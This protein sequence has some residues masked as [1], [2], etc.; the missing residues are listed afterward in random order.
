MDLDLLSRELLR[1]LRGRRSQTAL[2]RRLGYQSNVLYTWEAGHRAPTAAE[3]LRLASR[4]GVDLRAA[5]RRFY[6]A[7]PA[8]LQAHDPATPA[9]VAAWLT[10]LR[11]DTPL[12]RVAEQSGLSRFAVARALSGETEPRLPDFL[13]LFEAMSLRVLDL[14]AALTDPELL[15]S[16]RE[17]WRR[18]VAQRRLAVEQPFT[19][20]VLRAVELQDYAD[21]PRHEEGW[22]AR[23]LGIAPEVE[24]A[25]LLLLGEA[26]ELRWDGERWRPAEALA[27]DTR[28]DPERSRQLK[29]WWAQVGLERLGQDPDGMW[30]YNVVS[31]SEADLRH[32]QELYRACFRA[33]RT[34]VAR[35]A[36]AER[37]VL[38]NTQVFA[39]DALSAPE[40]DLSV[41]QQRR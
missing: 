21:L 3:A 4:V 8:W 38:I 10:D 16:T 24:A 37:V 11:G 32:I 36:P 33:V 19:Q 27:V 26:G 9:G 34:V 22:I 5:A 30:S 20:A 12:V 6:R 31:V 17:R 1:A 29:R 18:L 13:R 35:S 7:E 39:L 40:A 28:D 15:P 23:R 25:C 2:S 14:V 41:Q